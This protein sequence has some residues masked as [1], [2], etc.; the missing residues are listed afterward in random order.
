R[1]HGVWICM[2]SNRAKKMFQFL[3]FSKFAAGLLR[4]DELNASYSVPYGAS[5][6]RLFQAEVQAVSNY[7]IIGMLPFH[8][9]MREPNAWNYFSSGLNYS[10]RPHFQHAY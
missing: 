6:N 8:L 2:Q 1:Q 4:N 9:V 10:T 7:G 5:E 3:Y